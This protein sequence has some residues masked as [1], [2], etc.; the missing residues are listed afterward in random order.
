[1]LDESSSWY[2]APPLDGLSTQYARLGTAS[3]LIGASVTS[4]PKAYRSRG[5]HS[6]AGLEDLEEREAL[7]NASL[8][9]DDDSEDRAYK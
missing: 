1:M 2:E 7:D 8:L 9:S 4:L 6:P 5:L 3:L